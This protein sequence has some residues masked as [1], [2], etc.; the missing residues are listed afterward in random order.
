MTHL[1]SKV[2]WRV[3]L[4]VVNG[5]NKKQKEG[6]AEKETGRTKQDK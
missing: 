1:T 3:L 5:A 6:K 2:A 4:F